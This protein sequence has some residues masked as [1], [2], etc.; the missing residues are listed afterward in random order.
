MSTVNTY[1]F[2]F[3]ARYGDHVFERSGWS[4]DWESGEPSKDA[5]CIFVLLFGRYGEAAAPLGGIAHE[6]MRRGLVFQSCEAASDYLLR[7][8]RSSTIDNFTLKSLVPTEGF[9]KVRI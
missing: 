9:F 4:S 2:C 6:D 5:D 7:L 8:I 3:Q 1:A